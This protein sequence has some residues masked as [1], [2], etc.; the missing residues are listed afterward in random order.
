M[1]F[2]WAK[3]KF[4]SI[5]PTEAKMQREPLWDKKSCFLNGPSHMTKIATM[6][7]YAKKTFKE[8]FSLGPVG[9]LP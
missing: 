7:I 8:S 6:A 9:Q 5:G 4:L 1:H 2:V 3:I